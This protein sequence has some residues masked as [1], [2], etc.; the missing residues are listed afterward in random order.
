MQTGMGQ[1]FYFATPQKAKPVLENI[2]PVYDTAKNNMYY[3]PY[4]KGDS[5]YIKEFRLAGKDTVHQFDLP[6]QYIIGSGQH[7]RFIV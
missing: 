6:I 2:S 1:S 3:K 5:M 7:A 4:F